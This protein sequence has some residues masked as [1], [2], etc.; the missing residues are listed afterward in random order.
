[1]TKAADILRTY[2]PNMLLGYENNL[3]IGFEDHTDPDGKL[4]RLEYKST[5]S[6]DRRFRTAVTNHGEP[7]IVRDGFVIY[8]QKG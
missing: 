8:T 4:F 7:S 2:N 1:M 3:T 5:H 6:G